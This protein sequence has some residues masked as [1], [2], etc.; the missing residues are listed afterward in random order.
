LSRDWPGYSIVRRTAVNAV[1]NRVFSG[2]EIK[3]HSSRFQI[4]PALRFELSFRGRARRL[5]ND[6]IAAT[7][8]SDGAGHGGR[9]RLF[10]ENPRRRRVLARDS[11]FFFRRARDIIIKRQETTGDYS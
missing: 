9:F 7:R 3:L 4:R 1:S 10:R 2:N 5:E 11:F 8:K 6:A